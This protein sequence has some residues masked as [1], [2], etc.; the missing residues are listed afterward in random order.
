[1]VPAHRASTAF[2]AQTLNLPL[3]DVED[4]GAVLMT[5]QHEPDTQDGLLLPTVITLA[6]PPEVSLPANG[7]EDLVSPVSIGG[8]IP[9][10]VSMLQPALGPAPPP[11]LRDLPEPLFAGRRL[12]MAPVA[13]EPGAVTAPQAAGARRVSAVPGTNED[14][15]APIREH[16]RRFNAGGGGGGGG[17]KA[18]GEEQGGGMTTAAETNELLAPLRDHIRRLSTVAGPMAAPLTTLVDLPPPMVEP[19][20]PSGNRAIDLILTGKA[21]PLRRRS[22]AHPVRPRGSM[23]IN[24]TN[25][26]R[27]LRRVSQAE[28]AHASRREYETKGLG[29]GYEGQEDQALAQGRRVTDEDLFNPLR[30]HFR[31][32]SRM[33]GP[34][35][36]SGI[37]T[38][39][40]LPGTPPSD[41]L[42]TPPSGR[43]SR[44]TSPTE[45]PRIGRRQDRAAHRSPS[46]TPA[47]GGPFGGGRGTSTSTFAGEAEAPL[48]VHVSREVSRDSD[49]DYEQ[50]AA[51]GTAQHHSLEP[52]KH[53]AHPLGDEGAPTPKG[54]PSRSPATSTPN[55]LGS[56]RSSSSMRTSLSDA[57]AKPGSRRPTAGEAPGSPPHRVSGAGTGTTTETPQPPRRSIAQRVSE[58]FGFL[59][60]LD[61]LRSMNNRFNDTDDDA[62]G[63]EVDEEDEEDEEGGEEEER[64]RGMEGEGSDTD[65]ETND[66]GRSEASWNGSVAWT[67]QRAPRQAS[68]VTGQRP[69]QQAGA[70]GPSVGIP[71]GSDREDQGGTGIGLPTSHHRTSSSRPSIAS[72]DPAQPIA[73]ESGRRLSSSSSSGGSQAPPHSL[74]EAVA[75]EE[76]RPPGLGSLASPDS[77]GAGLPVTSEIQIPSAPDPRSVG[78]A[79]GARR[80]TIQARH[81]SLVLGLQ[82]RQPMGDQAYPDGNPLL[83]QVLGVTYPYGAKRSLATASK[84]KS[85]EDDRY[86]HSA[87]QDGHGP[88]SRR[89]SIGSPPSPRAFG[90]GTEARA[91]LV[92]A[93]TSPLWSGQR[94]QS[95]LQATPTTE[96]AQG[97]G[98]RVNSAAFLKQ[99]DLLKAKLD[100]PAIDD[101]SSTDGETSEGRH[102]PR[103]PPNV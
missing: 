77:K 37:I 62:D 55:L 102:T 6:T 5:G 21:D 53:L 61:A 3:S 54:S 1:M 58:S 57:A 36:A 48:P 19:I 99:L 18:G 87:S 31:R 34:L 103:T 20:E 25:A 43:R 9:K 95:G 45:S 66:R 2:V 73:L 64:G 17:T 86:P 93:G 63:E 82:L 78:A 88:P 41:L 10:R 67:T 28:A 84:G 12:S 76:R 100:G 79:N 94:L 44:H 98:E 65:P 70:A 13:G 33:E 80:T 90:G 83:N 92:R 8:R 30:Q 52:G 14:I 89:S 38:R 75:G 24:P 60:R 101:A 69:S 29:T 7:D 32:L 72:P 47:D 85:T 40:D 50:G 91:G 27:A 49:A 15:L 42:G 71:S 97:R 35:P 74:Q 56:Q 16:M 46:V 39:I 59:K 96:A 23:V 68:L 22:E 4:A 11:D 51:L 26:E 81:D